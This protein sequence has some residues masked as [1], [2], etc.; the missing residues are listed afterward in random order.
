MH[1]PGGMPQE[2]CTHVCECARLLPGS[3][4][5]EYVCMHPCGSEHLCAHWCVDK[6]SYILLC[7]N[8]SPWP[9]GLRMCAL[10]QAAAWVPLS[11]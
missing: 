6:E 1:V 9:E 2:G 8:T 11:M 3:C 7:L 5:S 4:E 10:P